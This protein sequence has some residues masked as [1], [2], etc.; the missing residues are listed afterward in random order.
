MCHATEVAI[1]NS[2]Q[3]GG[4][5]ALRMKRATGHAADAVVDWD[6][7]RLIWWNWISIS[8]VAVLREVCAFEHGCCGSCTRKH[9]SFDNVKLIKIM[10]V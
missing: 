8:N 2:S 7:V 6:E 5:F 9:A 1:F 4:T 3:L 10:R